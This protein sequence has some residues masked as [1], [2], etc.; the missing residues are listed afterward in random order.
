MKK[1]LMIGIGWEQVPMVKKAKQMGLYVIVT[2]WWNKKKIPADKVFSIDSRD[3]DE[4]EQLF[5]KEKPDYVIADEC[6][7]SMY[8]VAYLSEKYHI[9]GPSLR[10]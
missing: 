4:I 2:T 10:V 7:Y 3:I 5:L 9:P 8:A 6:D 1:I